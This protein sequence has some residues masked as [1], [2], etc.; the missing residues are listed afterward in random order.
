MYL[1][2]PSFSG[3]A[4]HGICLET[5]FHSR[6]KEWR[7]Y[8]AL[9]GISLYVCE[10]DIWARNYQSD[11]AVVLGRTRQDAQ[12]VRGREINLLFCK[13]LLYCGDAV[14]DFFLTWTNFFCVLKDSPRMKCRGKVTGPDSSVYTCTGGVEKVHRDWSLEQAAAVAAWE[15][16]CLWGWRGVCLAVWVGCAITNCSP[17]VCLL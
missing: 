3:M 5:G 6:G 9:H 2:R 7:G 13:S 1:Y 15:K 8:P 14:Q 11:Y 4:P 10:C 17:H 16:K 12:T